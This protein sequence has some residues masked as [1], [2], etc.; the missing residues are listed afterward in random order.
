MTQEHS[1]ATAQQNALNPDCQIETCQPARETEVCSATDF[2]V[3][4]SQSSPKCLVAPTEAPCVIQPVGSTSDSVSFLEPD[5]L[6]EKI[7]KKSQ[8]NKKQSFTFRIIMDHFIRTYMR[9][10]S[11]EGKPLTMLMTGPEG[12]GKTHITK[13]VQHMMEHYRCG[14]LIRFFWLQLGPQQH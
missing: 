5:E 2:A 9:K 1:I 4:D 14:H 13:A 10:Q 8:L 6:I 11:N 3:P 7:E 12:T